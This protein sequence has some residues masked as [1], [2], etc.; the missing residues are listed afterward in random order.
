MG[1][2]DSLKKD[3]EEAEAER[4]AKENGT[5]IYRPGRKNMTGPAKKNALIN[6]LGTSDLDEVFE[7][8]APHLTDTV[9]EIRDMLK[10]EHDVVKNYHELSGR[11]NELQKHYDDLQKQYNALVETMQAMTKTNSSR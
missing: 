1:F 7:N 8:C 4:K 9:Y 6:L 11:Y 2:F 3:W 5:Y 10:D